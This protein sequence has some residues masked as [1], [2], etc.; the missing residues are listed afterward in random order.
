VFAV[1]A[2]KLIKRMMLYA[3]SRGSASY[4]AGHALIVEWFFSLSY[5]SYHWTIAGR[6]ADQ[7]VVHRLLCQTPVTGSAWEAKIEDAQ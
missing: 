7:A 1:T 2:I 4:N 3:K 6:T 5:G